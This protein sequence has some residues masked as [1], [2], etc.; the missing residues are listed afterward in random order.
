MEQF[1]RGERRKQAK[2]LKKNRKDYAGI[3]DANDPRV[4]LGRALH[5]PRLCS[6][7]LCCNGKGLRPSEQAFFQLSETEL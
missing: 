3:A 5:T 2:R 4:A 6:C 7:R 1:H